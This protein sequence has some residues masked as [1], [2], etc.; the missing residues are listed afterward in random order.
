ML[1]FCRWCTFLG[2]PLARGLGCSGR[3]GYPLVIGLEF[4]MR[5]DMELSL[6]SK[7]FAIE[8]RHLMK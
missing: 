7:G 5:R 2:M 3:K 8:W 4:G 1:R 6:I